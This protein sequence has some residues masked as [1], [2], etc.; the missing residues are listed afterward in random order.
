MRNINDNDIENNEEEEME[1]NEEAE[2]VEDP[3]KIID[4][5]LDDFVEYDYKK[6]RKKRDF[7]ALG[8]KRKITK[9]SESDQA[10]VNMIKK[11][12]E[13]TQ[14]MTLDDF[15]AQYGSMIPIEN[16]TEDVYQYYFQL[17]KT[18]SLIKTIGM[19]KQ[20]C[21]GYMEYYCINNFDTN[22]I[23]TDLL[24]W[25]T[26]TK[27]FDV[28]GIF[29][30]K[31]YSFKEVYC[32]SVKPILI[33]NSLEDVKEC[34]IQDYNQSF[35]SP[36]WPEDL[37]YSP[38]LYVEP[39]IE[40][41]YNMKEYVSCTVMER[42]QQGNPVEKCNFY[43]VF[44]RAD[45][46]NKEIDKKKL[47]ENL[48]EFALNHRYLK[49]DK[50]DLVTGIKK[51]RV[52]KGTY[53]FQKKIIPTDFCPT[54]LNGLSTFEVK[55]LFTVRFPMS[56][57]FDIC[58]RKKK[59]IVLNFVTF[60]NVSHFFDFLKVVTL[61]TNLIDKEDDLYKFIQDY[62]ENI[63]SYKEV[64]DFFVFF[65]KNVLYFFDS[66]TRRINVDRIRLVYDKIRE[67]MTRWRRI[68]QTTLTKY[69][70][71]A[72]YINKYA[73]QMCKFFTLSLEDFLNTLNYCCILCLSPRDDSGKIEKVARY[74]GYAIF[75][76]FKGGKDDIFNVIRSQCSFLENIVGNATSKDV[77][78]YISDI[79]R[80]R[81]KEDISKE[82]KLSIQEE[83]RRNHLLNQ[84]RKIDA[85]INLTG[86]GN[87]QLENILN[88]LIDENIEQKNKE[89][90]NKRK[91][92]RRKLKE[93]IQLDE[94]L[95][96]QLI[97]INTQNFYNSIMSGEMEAFNL[98]NTVYN[99][100]TP[101]EK[102]KVLSDAGFRLSENDQLGIAQNWTLYDVFVLI[103]QDPTIKEKGQMKI[104]V[105][106]AINQ[107]NMDK[108]KRLEK[109]EQ[110][111]KEQLKK[112]EEEDQ[113]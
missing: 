8:K 111:L 87:D 66:F 27:N 101:G 2:R 40:Y 39:I 80:S 69:S 59:M 10:V 79:R 31:E 68:P 28:A 19:V 83:A 93:E 45:K 24:Y 94:N 100:F 3:T 50:K 17:F 48:N 103:D 36:D 44:T 22:F 1:N 34:Y 20:L 62:N 21:P 57:Y 99:N 38:N 112:E 13:R 49:Y 61:T 88:E 5:R 7:G 70:L 55:A 12:K 91:E 4:I 74:C 76:L 35:S 84:I 42:Q 18:S 113:Q 104:N 33:K 9:R 43:S 23:T 72:S 65:R 107:A 78:E 86:F 67:T 63:E 77:A 105:A 106:S 56:S 14:N 95:K 15:K 54:T 75:N 73:K 97:D 102:S 37:K 52:N 81:K 109:R 26:K 85:N 11:K 32:C 64:N 41:W 60:D 6:K 29:E 108:K 47:Q 25:T 90:I 58:V 82:Q 51:F 110:E 30:D 16:P 89:K 96:K 92:H 71:C 46:N 98:L 53:Y